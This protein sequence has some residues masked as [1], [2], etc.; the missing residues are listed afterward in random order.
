[1]VEQG[2]ADEPALERIAREAEAEVEGAA[3]HAIE[4]PFPDP[5]EVDEHVYAD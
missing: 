1:M 2:M 4:A 5:R 3:E